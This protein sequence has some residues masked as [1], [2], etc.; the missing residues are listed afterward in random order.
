MPYLHVKFRF[1]HCP[2]NEGLELSEAREIRRL[3]EV[4]WKLIKPNV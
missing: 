1:G 2:A 3:V 4:V